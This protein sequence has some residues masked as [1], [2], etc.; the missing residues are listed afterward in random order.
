MKAVLIAEHGGL[1]RLELL[2]VAAPA[3]RPGE[4]LVRVKAAALNHLDLWVRRGVPGHK[5]PLPLIPGC[6]GAGVVEALGAGVD[7]M[8]VGARVAIA[9][10]VSCGRCEPCLRGDDAL[11]RYFGILGETQ[12]GTCAELV[13]IPARNA[14]AIPEAMPFEQAAAVSLAFLTAWHMIVSRAR[15]AAGETV[16][17][18]AGGSG[19]GSCAIQILKLLHATVITTVSS[20][21]KVE[22]ARSLGADHVIDYQTRDF[23]EA[24]RAITSKR[25]VDVVIDSV[26]ADT[27]DRSIRSLTKGGRYVTCGATSGFELK[28]DFRYVYFK[29]LSILG[30]T[31]GGLHE[32]LAVWRHVAAGR[33]RPLLFKVLPLHEIA[34][35]HRLLEDRTVFG[36]V[37]VTP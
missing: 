9:P 11:C 10:G 34:A 7:G 13:S 1:D 22:R 14:I 17:V 16:L 2:D 8:A 28:T 30:S 26:G 18:H 35:A 27:F 29:S 31:M 5:F 12:N 32:V 6:D 23:A 25:G 4:V 15:V 33:L 37:V 36:K 20:D 19:V 21:A 24:V 3:P